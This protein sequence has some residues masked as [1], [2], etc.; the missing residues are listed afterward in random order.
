MLKPAYSQEGT[1]E[2]QQEEASY[3]NFMDFLD[4][5]QGI[6]SYVTA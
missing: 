4:R 3:I 1:P 5:C 2:R 6:A